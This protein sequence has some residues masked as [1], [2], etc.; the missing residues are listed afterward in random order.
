MG[1]IIYK[2]LS[3]E[4]IG[5]MY[6]AYNNLGFGYREKVFHRAFAKELDVKHLKYKQE[7]PL[8]IVYKGELIGKYYLDFLIENKII[9]EIKVAKDFY[10]KDIKQVLSYLKASNLKLGILIIITKE[11][12][13]YRRVVN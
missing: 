1:E 12:I 5:A 8:K 3:Y 11:G 10:T 4:V 6:E 13:K 2:E 7:V 9:I